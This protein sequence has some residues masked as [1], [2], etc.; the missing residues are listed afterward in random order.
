MSIAS[1][2]AARPATPRRIGLSSITNERQRWQAYEAA[3]R[4]WEDLHPGASSVEH[5]TAMQQLAR[6]FGV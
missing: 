4:L 1:K 5:E 2:S 6:R 3:K